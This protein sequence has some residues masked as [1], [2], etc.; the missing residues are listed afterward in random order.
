MLYGLYQAAQGANVQTR[1]LEVIANNLAN[2]NTTSFKR[3]LAIFQAR[4]LQ[5]HDPHGLTDVPNALRGHPGMIDVADVATDFANGAL[6]PTG[7]K[8]DVALNGPGFF[9]VNNGTEDL[10]TRSGKFSLNLNREIVQT[11]TNLPILQESNEPIIVPEEAVSVEFANDG[12]VFAVDELNNRALLGRVH[13]VQSAE[14]SELEKMGDSLF[15]MAGKS[16]TIT[17]AGPEVELQQGFLELSSVQ[18]IQEMLEL[19]ETSRTLEANMNM[20]QYQEDTLGQ[21]LQ[22][23]AQ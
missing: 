14:P 6:D 2:A 19:I 21:L 3:D 10:L 9:R 7:G 16:S 22:Q 13:I 12:S 4:Q 20:I 23:A 18:P 11:N 8:M 17:T 1:R 15:R 5:E